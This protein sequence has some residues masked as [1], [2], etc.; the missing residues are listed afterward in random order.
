[1]IKVTYYIKIECKYENE[2]EKEKTNPLIIED[3]E[4]GEVIIAP[5]GKK[6]LKNAC[7]TRKPKIEYENNK[8]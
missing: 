3:Y 2:V 4:K 5:I 1:M 8:N 7:I 6:H